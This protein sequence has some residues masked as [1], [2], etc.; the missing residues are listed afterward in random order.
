MAAAV[1]ILDDLTPF[2]QFTPQ[3]GQSGV[4]LFPPASAF[5]FW[6]WSQVEPLGDGE[7]YGKNPAYGAQISYFA[8]ERT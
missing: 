2:Q 1:W 8:G 4:H 6:P 5:R 3:T 7:F